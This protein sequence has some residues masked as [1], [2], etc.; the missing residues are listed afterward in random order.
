MS[1][2][3]L[4]GLSA[5]PLTPFRGET[6]DGAAL[7]R[8][9]CRLRDAEV[10]SITV[11]GSTGSGP[12]LSEAE[13]QR[14]LE[15]GM[16]HAGSVPLIAGIAALRTRD[17]V[18]NA[19]EAAAAGAR[20]VLL[21]PLQYQSLSDDEVFGLFADVASG[22]DLP[23]VLY[24]NPGTTRFTFSDE[25][26]ARIGAIASVAAVKVP[27]LPADRVAKEQRL[28][29]LRGILPAATI[30]GLSG[31]AAAA[32]GLLAG[33][34]AWYSVVAGTLPKPA[35]QIARAALAGDEAAARAANAALAG[36]W[37]LN[38]ELGSLRVVAAIAEAL[39]LTGP[40][41]LPLPVRGLDESARAGVSA[42]LRERGIDPGS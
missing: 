34:D 11:L 10:D 7:E 5:F 14:A 18:R 19:R 41:S 15:I 12:Y 16:R 22:T 28:A 37:E 21:A 32:E 8:I 25:L 26:I 30:I 39:G 13:R 23:I 4:R 6:L 1:A 2:G 42:W 31:D 3:F 27:P 36:L 20:A 40:N 29:E 33:A 24:D 17:A 38:S 9:I 35:L